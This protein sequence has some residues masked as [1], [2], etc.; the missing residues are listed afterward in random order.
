MANKR[1]GWTLRKKLLVAFL[2]SGL[3]P[4]LASGLITQ[5]MSSAALQDAANSKL[6]AIKETK[7]SQITSYLQTIRDQVITLSASPQT[8]AA[9]K[10]FDS[11][12]HKEFGIRRLNDEEFN[13]FETEL[14]TYYEQEF[15]RV[16]RESNDREAD[17]DALFP[18]ERL[19]IFRQYKYIAGNPN[20][21]GEKDL[22]NMSETNKSPYDFEH[23]EY[24]PYFRQYL[25][26]FGYYDIF[27]VDANTGHIVYSVFKELD[28]GT[29]LKTGPYANTNFARAYQRALGL[30][31]RDAVV[32]E[33]F[34]TYTPSYEAAASF[35]AS[36][37]F[38]EDK[39][40]GVLVFQMPVQRI[41]NIMS[42][43]DGLGETGETY[44]V[45]PDNLMRSQARYIDESTIGVRE[46]NSETVVKALAGQN[47]AQMIADS[48]GNSILSS[49]APLEVL[50][51]NWAVMAEV[52]ADEA[53]AA[54]DSFNQAIVAVLIVAT[55]VVLL[56]TWYMVRGVQQQLGADPSDILTIT[57]SIAA[58]DLD[59]EVNVDREQAVG[60]LSSLLLMRRNLRESIEKDRKINAE[61][62]RI[63]QALDVVSGNIMLA[64]ADNNIIYLNHAVTRM[65]SEAEADIRRDIPDF[66]ASQLI[67][68]NIDKFHKNPAHQQ[69]MLANMTEQMDSGLLVGGRTM[70][71][72]AN[73][74]ITE[75]GERLGTVVEWVDQTLEVA[76]QKEIEGLIAAARAG[77]LSKSIPLQDKQGFFRVLSEG[78]N[79]LLRT[80]ALVFDDV[81]SVM[82]TL[83]RG[84]LQQQITSDYS[85]TFG[86]VKNNVNSTILSL[87]EIVSSIRSSTELITSGSDEI[88]TGNNALSSR[89]E[90]QASSLEET[91]SAMEE[92]TSTVRQ[93][94]DN[95]REANQL[96]DGAQSTA[97]EGSEIVGDAIHAMEEISLASGKISEIV[98][99]IDE[100]AFQTN[101]LALNASVEAARAGEQGR[102]FAVVATEV[103]NLAQRSATS[104]REIK[105]LIVDSVYKVKTGTELV[106]RSGEALEDIMNSV[107]KVGDI[108][109]EISSASQEQAEGID[110][111]N[112]TV[113]SLD[114]LTQ[115]NAALAEQTSAASVSMNEHA[116]NMKVQV[117]FFQIGAHETSRVEKKPSLVAV[118]QQPVEK[119]PRSEKPAAAAEPPKP[120]AKPVFDLDDDDWE[121]F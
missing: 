116:I 78:M 4:L 104:A 91:A 59:T 10:A 30:G 56:I 33:D 118:S 94:A 19:E 58:G 2:V 119:A 70:K 62:S 50:G 27:L 39:L 29:S 74:V 66:D 98:G 32:L 93:N 18:K 108:V 12:F 34:E 79:E 11:A 7:R 45:G 67:G 90:Q 57:G 69:H 75:S 109:A 52:N 8:V 15:G 60:V 92:L 110:Q 102:G 83:S 53:L 26:K 103:R 21:L 100:I 77:D 113:A 68:S 3:V 48:D 95:A 6:V 23:R 31:D 96:S 55:L 40:V 99:V 36:P 14:R 9:M 41:N 63:K 35:I 47:G 71:F 84:D 1:A 17:I 117:D 106:N 44:L 120:V 73:P 80:M 101:L 121:E 51:L 82:E 5:R 37:V 86:E 87:L 114:D 61:M 25:H 38:E 28:Y 24:H 49:Y 65:F 54:I 115:Q 81:A 105:D 16:Y 76:I 46:V 20:P 64:D 43:T 112:K 88:S 97:K 22:L 111:I 85:G 89:T 13:R 42:A 107:V 72:T